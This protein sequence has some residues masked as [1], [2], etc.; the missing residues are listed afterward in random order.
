MTRTHVLLLSNMEEDVFAKKNE[1]AI[2]EDT[3]SENTEEN[4]N[5]EQKFVEKYEDN[6]IDWF[7][8]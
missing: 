1:K 8:H 7:K 3:D 2:T 5:Y 4:S 6:I